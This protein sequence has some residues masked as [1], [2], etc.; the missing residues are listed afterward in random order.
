[1][2]G[3]KYFLAALGMAAI[4]VTFMPRPACANSGMPPNP[5]AALNQALDPKNYNKGPAQPGLGAPVSPEVT[6]STGGARGPNDNSVLK[7]QGEL[8]EAPWM[9]SEKASGAGHNAN[10]LDDFYVGPTAQGEGAGID[11]AHRSQ[12]EVA[13]FLT[14][15]MTEMLSMG[16]SS[17]DRNKPPWIYE[18]HL[19]RLAVGLD[20]NALSNFQSFMAQSNTIQ[21]LQDNN[22][23][24]RIY[25]EATP[26][27]LNKGKMD[28]GRYHWLYE[29]PVTLSFLDPAAKTYENKPSP[30][31]RR[32]IIRTQVGHVAKKVRK[33]DPGIDEMMIES[34]EVR[35]NVEKH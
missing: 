2:A 3:Q 35:E 1:M 13:D 27:L 4:A 5:G 16:N 26:A 9:A 11:A 33:E 34:F 29:M 22:L 25:I 30:F 18:E 7:G 17:A 19:K 20:A 28:D 32:V 23:I 31:N 10:T 24:L 6:R 14:K 21:T 8:Q 12:S 15:A